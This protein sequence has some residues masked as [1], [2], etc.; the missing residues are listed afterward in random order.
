MFYAEGAGLDPAAVTKLCAALEVALS[1][2][3]MDT[4]SLIALAKNTKKEPL[5]ASVAGPGQAVLDPDVVL[6]VLC[7]R[8]D[9]EASKYLK[10][11]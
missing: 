11:E 9:Y 1:A 3:A 5:R 6:R 7:H 4:Q 2:M 10:K 8:A